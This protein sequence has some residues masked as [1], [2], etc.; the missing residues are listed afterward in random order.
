MI[1]R[2][3]IVTGT[4]TLAAPLAAYAQFPP[5][6]VSDKLLQSVENRVATP[7]RSMAYIGRWTR[8]L[9][10]FEG[11]SNAM[12]AAEARVEYNQSVKS[13]W[14]PVLATLICLEI[15]YGHQTG[16]GTLPPA[17]ANQ[18]AWGLPEVKVWNRRYLD[19]DDD[20][21]PAT[22]CK[23]CMS[24]GNEIDKR[25]EERTKVIKEKVA[26]DKKDHLGEDLIKY[27]SVTCQVK[28]GEIEA[29]DL[30]IGKVGSVS[31]IRPLESAPEYGGPVPGG[32]H[33]HNYHPNRSGLYHISTRNPSEDDWDSSIGRIKRKQADKRLATYILGPNDI[34]RKFHWDDRSDHVGGDNP[35]PTTLAH[36]VGNGRCIK[37]KN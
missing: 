12:S 26:A 22:P 16:A 27:S 32:I 33:T 18:P 6:C 13:R 23:S 28:S 11:Y 31:M 24:V 25:A 15:K 4:L 14:G 29:T 30:N 3:I 36:E 20:K 37:K 1:L 17:T 35:E 19:N 21:A 34:E 8:V 9:N 2:F 7:G 5:H 10:A